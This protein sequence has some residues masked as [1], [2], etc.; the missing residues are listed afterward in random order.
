[1]TCLASNTQTNYLYFEGIYDELGSPKD[2]NTTYK[3]G[4][5]LEGVPMTNEQLA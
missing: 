2:G 1:M 4:R 3:D 5:K